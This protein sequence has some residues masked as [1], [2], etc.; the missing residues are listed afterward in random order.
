MRKKSSAL[1]LAD[2]WPVPSPEWV[3][4]GDVAVHGDGQQAEDGALGEHEDEAS[5]E[6]AAVEVGAEAGADVFEKNTDF[7]KTNVKKKRYN[8]CS[9]AMFHITMAP[10]QSQSFHVNC[11]ALVSD[12]TSFWVQ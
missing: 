3:L 10:N 5:D 9:E 8:N 2:L 12:N 7:R 1:G 11:S 4:D 6:Q